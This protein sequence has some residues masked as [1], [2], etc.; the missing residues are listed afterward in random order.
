MSNSS[1]QR[2]PPPG[3]KGRGLSQSSAAIPL[4]LVTAAPKKPMN[5]ASS[6]ENLVKAAMSNRLLPAAESSTGSHIERSTMTSR[7]L[8]YSAARGRRHLS[9]QKNA[10]GLRYASPQTQRADL[11]R[12]ARIPRAPAMTRTQEE[13]RLGPL[14]GVAAIGMSTGSVLVHNAAKR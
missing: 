9:P 5:R 7:P 2:R 3:E 14:E 12:A 10:S 13:R 6:H 1:Q 4:Q 11:Q 8:P